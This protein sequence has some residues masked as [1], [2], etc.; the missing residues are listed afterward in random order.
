MP[1]QASERLFTVMKD[2]N[3]PRARISDHITGTSARRDR[4]IEIRAQY[5]PHHDLIRQGRSPQTSRL[6]SADL[7]VRRPEKIRIDIFF[8]LPDIVKV[9]FVGGLPA[10][11]VILRVIAHPVALHQYPLIDLRVGLHVLPYAEKSG[12]GSMPAQL[13]QHKR[14]D[15]RM[16]AIVEGE[17]EH[18]V[19][20]RHIPDQAGIPFLQPPGRA[21][22]IEHSTTSYKT[23]SFAGIGRWSSGLF[24][25][26]GSFEGTS[27]IFQKRIH[28][29]DLAI[30]PEYLSHLLHELFLAG[31]AGQ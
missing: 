18:L 15:L 26:S 8:R 27:L 23:P 6:E 19:P 7:P 25:S 9:L 13:I 10:I 17:I 20:R 22:Q 3:R 14:R 11:Q 29:N 24:G 1:P 31:L 30:L 28:M 12:F 4:L 2:D 16:R 5:S 21:Y